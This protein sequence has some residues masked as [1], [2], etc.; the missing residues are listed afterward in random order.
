MEGDERR[1]RAGGRLSRVRA[2]ASRKSARVWPFASLR[3]DLVVEGFDRAGDEGA[4]GLAQHGQQVAM[5]EQV[6]DL[7]GDVVGE[8][9]AFAMQRLDDRDGVAGAVEEIGVAEGDVRGAGGHLAADVF[10][11]DVGLHDAEQPVIHRDHR[12]VA[13]EVLAAARGL[14]VADAA[15]AVGHDELRVGAER[16][17]PAAVGDEELLAIQRD[18]WGK[19]RGEVAGEVAESGFEFAAE[20]GA[21]ADATQQALVERGVEAVGGRGGL[22]G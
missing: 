14:G 13:A 9:R 1:A 6:L 15:R 19:S 10:E 8:P 5:L 11:H 18:R 2:R 17:Q 12:T 4:A 21:D 22:A 3:E 20:D 7:D 16:R